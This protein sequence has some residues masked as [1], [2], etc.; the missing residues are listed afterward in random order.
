MKRAL[1]NNIV[2]Y[3]L[4]IILLAMAF[5]IFMIVKKPLNPEKFPYQKCRAELKLNTEHEN[6]IAKISVFFFFKTKNTGQLE[7]S[8]HVYN[9]GKKYLVRGRID[10]NYK[11]K[12]DIIELNKITRALSERDM[13][14]ENN[15]SLPEYLSINKG[16][17]TFTTRFLSPSLVLL[18]R[19]NDPLFIMTCN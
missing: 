17:I 6:K 14:V 15:T 3:L 16:S 9:V 10:F 12:N 13:S 1:K 4:V 19:Y 8:G 11:F 18:R 7:Y 2:I 5:S